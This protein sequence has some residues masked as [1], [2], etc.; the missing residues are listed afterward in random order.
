MPPVA[1][2]SRTC[3]PPSTLWPGRNAPRT[4]R[5]AARAGGSPLTVAMKV[6]LPLV[7]PSVAV[8]AVLV[9]FLGFELFGLP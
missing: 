3:L 2:T 7:W 4:P 1:A 9:A 8:S 6:T 5:L